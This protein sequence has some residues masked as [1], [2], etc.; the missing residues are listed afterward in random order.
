MARE[1]IINGRRI[2]QSESVFG[3]AEIGH[4]HGADIQKAKA[5]VNTAKAAGASAVKFQT[6]HPKEVYA[7]QDVPGGYLYKADNLQW[8][9]SE[10]G[11]HREKL[12]FSQERWEELFKYCRGKDMIAFSTPLDFSSADQ[13]NDLGVPAFKIASGDATN[14]PLIQHVS[15]FNKP[16]IISTGGLGIEDVDRIHDT[17]SGHAQFALLQCSCIY[18]APDDVMNLNVISTYMERYPDVVVG[19]STHNRS[20]QPTV[21]AV[22]MGARIFEHSYTNNKS[23]KGTD[24]HFSLDPGEMRALVDA[25]ATVQT[26]LG[27]RTKAQDPKEAS[28]TTERQKKLVWARSASEKEV[29]TRDH[30]SILSPGDGVPPYKMAELIGSSVIK[31]VQHGTDVVW[32]DTLI[33]Y[34][35]GGNEQ[36]VPIGKKADTY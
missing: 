6:R 4:N 25:C 7:M 20:W 26:S 19:L 23:W 18:P 2:A 36:A 15:N 17:L 31:D 16:M 28:Y 35:Q 10:Y 9:D 34:L 33:G 27:S 22:A 5:M 11:T 8:M 32:A 12:E 13:L 14:I 29:L 3:I 21:A 1:L 30:F 24:N